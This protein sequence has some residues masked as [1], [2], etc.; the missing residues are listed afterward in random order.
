MSVGESKTEIVGSSRIGS[1]LNIGRE[2]QL[3]KVVPRFRIQ[4]T[5]SE[6]KE[7]HAKLRQLERRD[8]WLWLTSIVVMLLLTSAVAFLFLP[9]FMK[10]QDIALQLGHSLAVRGLLGVVLLFSTYAIY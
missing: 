4:K 2:E 1:T 5:A 8:W 3:S 9:V 7:I 10:A 6:V